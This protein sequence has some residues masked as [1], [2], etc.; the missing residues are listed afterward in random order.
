MK[1][2]INEPFVEYGIDYKENEMNGYLK[3]SQKKLIIL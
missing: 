2:K 3:N 1:L